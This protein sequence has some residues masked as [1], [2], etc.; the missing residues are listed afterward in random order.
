MGELHSIAVRPAVRHDIESLRSAEEAAAQRF[1]SIGMAWLAD[2]SVTPPDIVRRYVEAGTALV[3]VPPTGGIAGFAFYEISGDTCYLAELSVVPAFA[4]QRLGAK[5]IDRVAA[6]A[7]RGGA[8]RMV[9]RTFRDVPWNA[10]YYARLGFLTVPAM[11]QSAPPFTRPPLD[12]IISSEAAGGLDPSRRV[13]MEKPLTS[14]P[15]GKRRRFGNGD[16]VR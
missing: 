2:A 14:R 9:L 5:L 4:G 1:R 16:R 15:A 7:L 3:A 12:T 6:R 11:A 13:F 10:P 8:V